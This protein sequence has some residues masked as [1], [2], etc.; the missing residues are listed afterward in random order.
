MIEKK[1]KHLEFIQ[2]TI[3]RM[4]NNSFLLKGWSITVVGALIGLNKDGLDAKVIAI[5]TFITF[6]FWILDAYFLKQE[7]FFRKRYDEVSK[8][9]EENID[10]SMKLDKP[11]TSNDNWVNVFFSVTLNI[12][13]GG[14]VVAILLFGYFMK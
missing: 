4:A 12:F 2:N 3:T 10:F 7:R 8:K 5:T 1:L 13:Y 11:L 6:M 14:I 9:E